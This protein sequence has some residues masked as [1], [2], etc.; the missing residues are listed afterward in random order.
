[1]VG[2]V[3]GGVVGGV[4]KGRTDAQAENIAA[5]AQAPPMALRTAT[6]AKVEPVARDAG[7]LAHSTSGVGPSGEA[8]T[9]RYGEGG[10]VERSTDGGRTWQRQA[11]GVST[12]LV[13]GSAT[14]DLVC[15]LV[16]PRGV[17]LR[18]T[19][20]RTWERLPSPTFADLV[21]VHAWSA[22][23]ATVTAADRTSYETADGGRTWRKREPGAALLP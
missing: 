2:Q 15:W 1:V 13:D 19:D 9:W 12:S 8:A 7:E 18:T 3:V 14:S 17:V 21:S 23:I 5:P 20:G 16:G 22:L 10:H 11:S 6:A 4:A